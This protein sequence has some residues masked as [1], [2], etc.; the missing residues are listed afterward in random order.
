MIDML[1]KQ[2]PRVFWLNRSGHLH[3]PLDEALFLHSVS[4]LSDISC[5]I[6]ALVTLAIVF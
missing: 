3:A 4:W 2:H 5:V 1:A 6:Q